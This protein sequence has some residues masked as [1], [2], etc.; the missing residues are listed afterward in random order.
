MRKM[1]ETPWDFR[2]HSTCQHQ[3]RVFHFSQDRKRLRVTEVFLGESVRFETVV[4]KLNCLVTFNCDIACCSVG[5]HLLVMAGNNKRIFA[6]LIDVG[7]EGSGVSSLHF[8]K[9][10]VKGEK[11]WPDWPFLCPISDTRIFLFF[12]MKTG[13]WYCDIKDK[14]LAMKQIATNMPERYELRSLPLRISDGKLLAL[15][16]YY[17][18]K[19]FT[20]I[21]CHDGL[22]FEK[23]GEIPGAYRG[24]TSIVL[25][26]DRFVVG[27]GGQGRSH[28]NDL[29]I[30]DLQTRQGSA[31]RQEGEWHPPAGLVPLVVRDGILY[32][33]GGYNTN[34]INSLPLWTL[35]CL[36][37]NKAIERAFRLKIGLPPRL[38]EVFQ[39]RLIMRYIVTLL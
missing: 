13:T 4:T 10:K 1:G 19:D 17:Y 20:L 36:I 26:A 38:H 2:S 25:V 32:L 30:F 27:F 33:L 39:R 35:S 11:A 21:S 31:V 5:Q 24:S 29:W 37:E 9:L 28:L 8:L 3:G 12:T 16:V 23:I 22:D 6:V 7:E 15:G 18:G 14:T 34:S